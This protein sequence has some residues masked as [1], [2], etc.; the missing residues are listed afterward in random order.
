M[1]RREENDGTN[2]G[3]AVIKTSGFENDKRSW[4]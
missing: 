3:I 1:G 2:R 4:L